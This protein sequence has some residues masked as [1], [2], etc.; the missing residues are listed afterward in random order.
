[1]SETG[2]WHRLQK[3]IDAVVAVYEH[4][5]ASETAT[6]IKDIRLA[7]VA[8]DRDTMRALKVSKALA[9]MEEEGGMYEDLLKLI[10]KTCPTCADAEGCPLGQLFKLE[11]CPV[12]KK[13][14]HILRVEPPEEVVDVLE[15]LDDAE[16]AKEEG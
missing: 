15:E 1:M 3:E 4:R 9:D 5:L 7:V 6:F 2:R 12:I 14:A 11:G 16:V 8:Y 10:Q 13:V